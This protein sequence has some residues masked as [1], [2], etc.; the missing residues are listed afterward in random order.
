MIGAEGGIRT[1]TGL[2]PT[3]FKSV[4]S[5]IS[6]PRLQACSQDSIDA[7]CELR[8]DFRL[9]LTTRPGTFG[10]PQITQKEKLSHKKAQKHKREF[11][12]LGLILSPKGYS[13]LE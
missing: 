8:C 12:Q 2:L 5:A 9:R 6:P 13:V 10:Y 11:R 3:D 7:G 4:A 1:H